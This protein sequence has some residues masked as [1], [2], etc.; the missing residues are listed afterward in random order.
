MSPT[1]GTSDSIMG[2]VTG[3]TATSVG[4]TTYGSMSVNDWRLRQMNGAEARMLMEQSAQRQ[5]EAMYQMAQRRIIPYMDDL[6]ESILAQPASNMTQAR[7]QAP[8]ELN[9]E[10]IM[11]M[12]EAMDTSSQQMIDDM[13]NAIMRGERGA[14]RMGQPSREEAHQEWLAE[15]ERREREIME[16]SRL[17]MREQSRL[18]RGPLSLNQDLSYQRRMDDDLRRLREQMTAQRDR[19]ARVQENPFR[20]IH[21]LNDEDLYGTSD[22]D[23]CDSEY[24]AMQK[25]KEDAEARAQ[26][27]LGS[28]IGDNDLKRYQETGHLFVQG[29]KY[30]Y[31]IPRGDGFI[32][33]IGYGVVQDMCVHLKRKDALPSTD[34]VIALKMFLE[35]D[36]KGALAMANIHNTWGE[37]EVDLPA[38]AGMN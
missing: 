22:W 20:D 31:I 11:Q 7:Q 16:R 24:K 10:A 17:R 35:N 30:K 6:E 36:E 34:N 38:C 27:L 4:Y 13:N 1:T 15:L 3:S 23:R 32:K 25:K 12:Q 21:W 33:K 8:P 14:I 9:M 26:E 28:L 19:Q 5:R 2:V 18:Q 29:R 37:E